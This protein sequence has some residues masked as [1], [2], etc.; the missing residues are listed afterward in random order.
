MS[1]I[2]KEFFGVNIVDELKTSYMDYAMSVI[3]SR[4]LPDVR[5]GLKPVQRR[6]LAA[7]NDLNLMPSASHR[8]SAK[9]AGDTSGNYHPHGEAI[10]YPTMVRMAQVFNA[11]YP[12]IDAQGNMGSIDG[13]P[14][15]AMRYTE[16]RM[17]KYAVEMLQDL[18]KDTVDWEPNYD[19]SRMEPLVLPA[20]LPNLLA[21]GSSGIAVGMATNIPPHNLCELCDGLIYLIDNPGCEVSDI[22]Q[23]IK[24]PDFPTYGIIRGTKGIRQAYETGRG[25]VIM[26]A[27]TEI[28]TLDNGRA[29]IIVT[30]LPY[31]VNKTALIE[32]I[33]RLAKEKRVDGITDIPDYS[34]RNGMR[35]Q[36]ELK[37][38]AQP[39]KILNYLY[40]HTELRKSFG[41]N[42]LALVNG[43]PNILNL[44]QVMSYYLEHRYN[45]V[46]RRTKHELRLALRRAHIVEGLLIAID[47]IDDV[48][49]IIRNAASAA[50]A[51]DELMSRYGLTWQQATA[52]L[53]MQLRQL[54]GLERGKLEEENTRLL[55]SIAAMEDLLSEDS[56]IFNLIKEELRQVKAKDGD[57]RRTFIDDKEASDLTDEDLIPSE[58]NIITLTKAGYVKRMALNEFHTQTRGG[59]GIKGFA[60]KD[61]DYLTN[62]FLANTHNTLLFFTDKGKVYRLKAYEIPVGSRQAGGS[63]IINLIDIEPGETIVANLV[64]E[65]NNEPG[66]MIMAT[67]RGEVKRTSMDSF[68]N[69]RSNG[70]KVFDVEEGDV[71]HWAQISDGDRDVILVTSK[72]KSIRFPEA[73][74]RSSGRTSGGVRGIRL[75]GDDKVVGM[76]L[77][78]EGGTLL[79]VTENGYGKQTSLDEYRV[80]GRGGK[81]VRTMN[82]T[83][84]TGRLIS[85]AAA[86]D[87]DSVL[88]V[89]SDR[90]VIVFELSDIRE[91]GRSTQGVRIMRQTSRNIQE[92]EEAK[93]VSIERMPSAETLRQLIEE[94]EQNRPGPQSEESL[95]EETDGEPE[96][97]DAE[98]YEF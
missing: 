10:I 65:S 50:A 78:R 72:G 84:K 94:A 5:D 17:S 69:I 22:M 38:D 55:K 60:V 43:A 77:S 28:E 4:A 59:T 24:G 39:K 92:G 79:C 1:E 34:D 74:I 2:A 56:K 61:N 67:E 80:Q 27:K 45:V 76:T 90:R 85:A 49:S 44:K 31:Q 7:M 87:S 83:D 29:A 23:F 9:I 48:V 12:L 47:N 32:K 53:D 26:E 13:D 62:I 14:P 20:K 42:M 58:Y 35:I 11:R 16:M 15:A 51:R 46:V 63:A 89:S 86:E 30:E 41:V 25:S 3:I 54:A 19:Q 98:P 66:F 95:P 64:L 68:R 36:I 70:L 81:G 71:L 52:I 18:D 93:V 96:E 91:T 88:A 33:A 75:D 97:T 40:K 37:K 6:I 8:K 73:D 57:E 82:C 21:N